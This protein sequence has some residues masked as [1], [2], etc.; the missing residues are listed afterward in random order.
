MPFV[1]VPATVKMAFFYTMNGQPAMN[2]IHIGTAATLPSEAICAA[3]AASGASWWDGN[4]RALVPATMQLNQVQ[5]QSIAEANGP[6]AT[7]SSGLPHA[8]TNGGNAM[9]NNVAFCVSLRSGLTGRSARGRWYHGG[10]T[11]DQVVGNDATAPFVAA[12]VA[13][14]D[15][16]LTTISGLGGTPV[17]VSYVSGGIPRPGGPVK[18]VITDALAVDATVDSQRG[19]LH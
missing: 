7:F 13:A 9:P 6:Q 11:E 17:I 4:I 3:F 16:L 10:L 12:V 18:F 5:V 8:G 2:R 19:R 14:I 15:N 1:A